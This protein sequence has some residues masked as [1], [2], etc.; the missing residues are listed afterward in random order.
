[1]S[2]MRRRSYRQVGGAVCGVADIYCPPTPLRPQDRAG[3][4]LGRPTGMRCEYSG[5]NFA[6][7]RRTLAVRRHFRSIPPGSIRG[8]RDLFIRKG[9]SAPGEGEYA[10]ADHSGGGVRMAKT[11]VA[12]QFVHV[13]VQAGVRRIYGVVGDSLNPMV[14]SIRRTDGW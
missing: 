4:R 1:M 9:A 3:R 11:N 14:D 8:D 10:A 13:L 7:G 2:C 12:D 5:G 6:N